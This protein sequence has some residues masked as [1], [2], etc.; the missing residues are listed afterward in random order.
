M[1]SVPQALAPE[2]TW[3]VCLWLTSD[4]YWDEQGEFQFP[5]DLI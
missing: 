1:I 4:N 5:L 3:S 2:Q